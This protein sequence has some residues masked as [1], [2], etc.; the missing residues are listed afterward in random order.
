MNIKA[1]LIELTH[2]INKTNLSDGE[3][4]RIKDLICF[5]SEWR[6]N[7]EQESL[8]YPQLDYLLYC[9]S[10]QIRV[11]GYNRL[12][13]F[14]NEK[15]NS[16]DALI[17]VKDEVIGKYYQSQ[18]GFTLDKAQKEVLDIYEESGQ[19]LFLSAPTSFGKTFLLK[20]I[21]YKHYEEYKNIIIVLPTVALLIEV[22]DEINAFID[23]TQMMYKTHN[24]IYRDLVLEERN[25]FILT[26]ERVLRLLAIAPDLDIDFFFFDEIY[27]IDE[28]VAIKSDDDCSDK[29]QVG[30][31]ESTDNQDHR[32]I[33]FRLTLYFLL[34]R[35]RACYLAGPF[36]ELHNLN[37]GFKFML[38]KHC[39]TPKEITF[40]PTLKNTIDFHGKT[41]IYKSPFERIEE[42]TKIGKINEKL[43]YVA[44]KLE[45]SKQNQAIVYCLYPASTEKYAKEF[46]DSFVVESEKNLEIDLFIEHLKNN[47][48]INVGESKTFDGW[49][50][51]YALQRQIGIHNGKFPKYFQ[52]EI[53]RMFN[54]GAMS[55]LFCTSTIVEGV[56]TNAKT[57][58]VYNNP[59]G[60]S[61][62]GKRFLL[63]NINGRAGRYQHHFV[64]NVV[65]LTNESIMI[66]QRD[67]ITL[68]FKPY[69]HKEL[70]SN[71]DLEN[72]ADDDL[73]PS[74]LTRKQQLVINRELLP[75]VVF[76]Q[77][78]LIERRKQEKILKL[79]LQSVRGFIGIERASIYEFIQYS[80][81]E[82]ILSIWAEVGEI[83]REQIPAIKYFS[84]NYAQKSYRGVLEYEFNR[85]GPLDKNQVSSSFING[86][87]RKVFRNVKDT[88]EYQ[89][90]RIISL[91]EVLINRAFEIEGIKT[92]KTLDLSNIVR[93]FEIGATSL[94]GI[95]MIE[96]G[97]PIV[98]VKKIENLPIL[99]ESLR[100]Q[101][102]EIKN[103]V[104]TKKSL[105]DRFEINQLNEYLKRY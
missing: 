21:I 1:L 29:I 46:A 47:Y 15:M 22:T 13:N 93:F 38:E 71:V 36:I 52:R 28:D 73:S 5:L 77:N 76:E 42:S 17:Y 99:G 44:K 3:R 4:S 89:L 48:D 45:I 68:N 50:F 79:I 78:R 70:L 60:K 23:Q 90:P 9:A 8:Q 33:A 32:A 24:S 55:V 100:E 59:S 43:V 83:K 61:E 64:G 41:F 72:I 11:F 12:N 85:N 18:T 84:I 54:N 34:Q 58:V 39:I 67:G 94:V 14:T 87:Y 74:N 51:V 63:L 6:K 105:F 19:K 86:T 57:V 25:I 27:K 65:Y 75:D 53:M 31:V 7:N 56:N 82:R 10:R 88:I 95:D 37:D 91:F 97:V 96:K 102:S 62:E 20:E 104:G 35:A 66:E 2:F 81:F 16:D 69:S 30:V 26:P 103:L 49:D 101:I 40:I 80:Y 92:S 98:T